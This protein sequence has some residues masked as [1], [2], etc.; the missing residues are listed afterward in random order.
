[1]CSHL[2][3]SE[4]AELSRLNA[5]VRRHDSIVDAWV[6]EEEKQILKYWSER[7]Q[8]LMNLSVY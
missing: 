7:K 4:E 6:K 8:Q 2:M 5:A 3:A 1:M